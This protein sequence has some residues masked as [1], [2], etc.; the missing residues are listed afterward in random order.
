M[1]FCSSTIRQWNIHTGACVSVCSGHEAYIYS[2]VTLMVCSFL[3]LKYFSI[4]SL[5]FV[6]VGVV[7]SSCL[8]EKIKL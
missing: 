6:A 7:P 4:G 5:F 8:V 2:L 3:S 1:L